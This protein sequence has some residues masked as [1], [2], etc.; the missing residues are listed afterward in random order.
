MIIDFTLSNPNCRYNSTSIILEYDY[1]VRL[2]GFSAFRHF[3]VP[4]ANISPN[5]IED[6]TKRR[7]ELIEDVIMRIEI[8]WSLSAYEKKVSRTGSESVSKI[9]VPITLLPE[10]IFDPKCS[11]N[12][13]IPGSPSCNNI[14]DSVTILSFG[15]RIAGEMPCCHHCAWWRSDPITRRRDSADWQ[16]FHERIVIPI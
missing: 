15:A 10:H 12:Q 16:T 2:I 5:E 8:T 11:I 1:S 7:D 6:A 13:P 3:V 14:R 4:C 9:S